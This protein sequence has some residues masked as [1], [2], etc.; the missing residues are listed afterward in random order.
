[1]A[2]TLNNVILPAMTWVDLYAATGLTVG[3]KIS[4]Q[5]LTT[6]DVRVVSKATMPTSADG[7]NYIRPQMSAVNQ[8]GDSGAWAFCMNGGGVNVSLST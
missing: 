3:A 2:N 8:A 4:V 5:N 7:F 1:M 6:G